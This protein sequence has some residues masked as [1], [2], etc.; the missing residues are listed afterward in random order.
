MPYQLFF[1][2]RLEYYLIRFSVCA[3]VV[4]AHHFFMLSEMLH[5]IYHHFMFLFSRI[6]DDESDGFALFDIDFRR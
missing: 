4:L 6:F 5:G 1:F 3:M 2:A